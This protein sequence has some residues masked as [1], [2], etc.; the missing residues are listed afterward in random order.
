MEGIA[1]LSTEVVQWEQR[2]VAFPPDIAGV[3]GTH[4]GTYAGS[5]TGSLMFRTQREHLVGPLTVNT[6]G[7]NSGHARRTYGPGPVLNPIRSLDH[8]LIQETI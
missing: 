7:T 1:P 5:G 4:I 2:S 6:G 3:L 8:L